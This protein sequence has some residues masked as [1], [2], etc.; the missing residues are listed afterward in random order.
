[1][2]FLLLLTALL[3]PVSVAAAVPTA[4]RSDFPLTDFGRHVV[5]LEEILDGGPPR[6]GI[7]AIDHPTFLPAADID[8]LSGNQPVISLVVAGNARAYPLSILMWHEIV[9]DTIGD[10]PVVVTFCPLC[11]AALA[12]E[13]TVEGQVLDFGTTGRLRHSDLVMYDRQTETWWQQFEGRGI[14]GRFAGVNLVSLPVRVEG[15][16]RFVERHPGG[17]VLQ[18]P[19]GSTRPYGYN[20]YLHYDSDGPYPRFFNIGDLPE[21][22]LPM[23]YVV[24]V[25]T[26]AWSLTLLRSRGHIEF[27]DLVLSW[28]PG[29][30]SALD[31]ER[32]GDGYDLG[33]VVVQRRDAE[34]RYTDIPYDL[35]FA[36]A[37]LAFRPDGQI[38]WQ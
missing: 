33:N 4:W 6:D 11:N 27:D 37:F 25:G 13:R 12:F 34:G 26:E 17:L 21:G 15:F 38:H 29:A 30:A 23:A 9:N 16:A 22:V 24:A 1:M 18:E 19:E 36:F 35:T 7:P 32:I 2:R 31:T 20:P 10:V 5:P 28:T 8:S 3:A 14:V